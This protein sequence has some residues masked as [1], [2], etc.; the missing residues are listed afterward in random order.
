MRLNDQTNSVPDEQFGDHDLNSENTKN[1]KISPKKTKKSLKDSVDQAHLEN[2]NPEKL[3]VDGD[4][5]I[6]EGGEDNIPYSDENK[7]AEKKT[8]RKRKKKSDEEDIPENKT[9]SESDAVTHN[10]EEGE[11]LE[12][13]KAETQPESSQSDEVDSSDLKSLRTNYSLLS[14]KDL[15]GILEDLISKH[16]AI[17]IRQ[18]VEAIKT[19]FYKKHKIE[20]E[21]KRKKFMQEGGIAEDYKPLDDQDEL[22]LRELLRKYRENRIETARSIEEEKQENLKKKCQVIEEIKE[23]INSQES[24]NKTFQDFRELQN[25]WREI[26]VVPQGS[27]N[28]LWENYHHYVEKFYDYIK[29]N[30]EL[31]DL[32][33][34]KNMEEKIQLCEKAE[35]LLL[36]PNIINAFN[37]LQVY[38]EAWREIGPVP[39]EKRAEIWDRFK[40]ATSKV[41]KKHQQ[42]YQDIKEQQR[43]NLEQKTI[44]CEKV[45]NLMKKTFDSHRDWVKTTREVLEIQKLWKTIGFAPKKDNNRIYSRFRTACDRF[46]EKKRG[47]YAQHLEEQN[48]NLQKKLDLC[49]QAETLSESTDWKTTTDELITLQKKWK[50]IGPV[51]RKHADGIWKR[52]RGACDRFFSRKSDYFKQIDTTYEANLKLKVSLINEIT[53]F[54]LSE[55]MK[56]N[57]DALQNFQRRWTEIG[58]VP[59]QRKEDIQHQYRNA[60]DRHFDNLKVDDL[61]KN[62]LKFSSRIEGIMQKPRSGQKLRFEREKYMN[63]LQQLKSDISVWE[64]N[65]GF[66]ANNENSEE[67]RRDFEK[68]IESARQKIKL[69]E[70]KINLIDEFDLDD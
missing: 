70:E 68:K 2:D 57:L 25:R 69:L 9:V 54:K 18:D 63:K 13:D 15:P 50:Q 51:P 8:V 24:I 7:P 42:Y 16:S 40:E 33:L 39:V 29:I 47:F 11:T 62:V 20:L 22:R 53:E 28:D 21:E 6:S 52:F 66:F 65:I 1:E 64:N 61:K 45:E 12:K 67:M 43:K 3:P 48:S 60:L 14:K 5:S 26:G 4:D 32:D 10:I 34:K 55:D 46:F 49:I 35:A 17:E 31:R 19:H 27:L 58:F 36:E 41:N 37:M 56:K 30:K 44:L 38:H 59:I 23:L